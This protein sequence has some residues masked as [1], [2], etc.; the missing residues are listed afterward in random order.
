[1]GWHKNE[2]SR[3]FLLRLCCKSFDYFIHSIKSTNFSI[4]RHN[5]HNLVFVL[6][7]PYFLYGMLDYLLRLNEVVGFCNYLS[8][9]ASRFMGKRWP[10]IFSILSHCLDASMW[11][12]LRQLLLI[13]PYYSF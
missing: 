6:A 12:P 1:M 3:L 7:K 5:I 2:L 10:V 11:E 9:D 13:R 4:G 8:V